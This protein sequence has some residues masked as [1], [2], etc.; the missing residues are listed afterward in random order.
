MVAPGDYASRDLH[1]ASCLRSDPQ[2]K[3][4]MLGRFRVHPCDPNVT[5]L[6]RFRQSASA[7]RKRRGKQGHGKGPGVA[8]TLSSRTRSATARPR[9]V[10]PRLLNCSGLF[11]ANLI[12]CPR[13]G[14][15]GF[16][17]LERPSGQLRQQAFRF[18]IHTHA[19]REASRRHAAVLIVC[20]KPFRSVRGK[21]TTRRQQRL[22]SG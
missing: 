9:L 3:G 15:Y 8:V 7:G 14:D 11:V 5:D 2:G 20:A 4:E 6:R 10:L 12:R 18:V 19:Q 21:V 13:T 17:R 16:R 1:S 22:G